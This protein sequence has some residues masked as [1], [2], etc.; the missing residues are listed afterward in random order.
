MPHLVA[1]PSLDPGLP[2]AGTGIGPAGSGG[3]SAAPGAGSADERPP[4]AGHVEPHRPDTREHDERDQGEHCPAGPARA[5]HPAHR[6]WARPRGR[7][8]PARGPGSGGHAHLPAPAAHP[9][10]HDG[11]PHP[12]QG[13]LPAA[14]ARRPGRAAVQHPGHLV[15]AG[16]QPGRVRGRRDRA[17]RRGRGGRLGHRGRAARGCGW[18]AGR[19]AP[20]WR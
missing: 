3:C 17:L 10:R 6:R 16:A 8:G 4:P 9:R 15:G 19:S 1:W 12:A 14:R 2:S 20:S 13:L 5:G 11:Q 18:W 7:A